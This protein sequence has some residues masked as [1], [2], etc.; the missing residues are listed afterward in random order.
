MSIIYSYPVKGTPSGDDLILISD[1]ASSPQF[2][3]KQIKVSSLPSSGSGITLTTTGTSG[4]AELNGIVLNIPNYSTVPSLPLNG[5]Q[6]RDNNGNFAASSDLKYNSADKTLTVGEQDQNS[7]TLFAAGGQNGT[8][9]PKPGALKLGDD[10]TSGGTITLRAPSDVPSG[11]Y[12]IILP[13]ARPGSNNKILESDANGNLSWIATPSG[14]G[15]GTPQGNDNNVQLKSGTS[16]AGSDD[17]DFDSNVLSVKHTVDIKGQGNSLP[18]GRLKLYCENSSHGVILEGP[19]HS[20][21]TNYTLKFPSA[22]PTN[23][24][25]LQYTTTGSLGWIATPS[26][27]SGISFNG[28]TADGIATYSSASTANVSSNLTIDNTNLKLNIGSTYSAQSDTGI[29]KIGGLSLSQDQESIEFYINGA[30]KVRI[31]EDGRLIASVGSAANPNLKL[32]AG[33]DGIYGSSN[34]VQLITNGTSKISISDGNA[35]DIQMNDLVEFG[36]GLRFGATGET[37]SSY[38]EGSWTPTSANINNISNASG[39]YVKIGKKVFAEFAFTMTGSTSVTLSGLPFSGVYTS[40]NKGA[41]VISVNNCTSVQ[42]QLVGGQMAT[43]TSFIFNA[44]T[45][46]GSGLPTK[47][48]TTTSSLYQTS[49]GTYAGTIIYTAS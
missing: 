44:Y 28:S 1:S 14:G 11:S 48:Q 49:G 22:A 24:Q 36:Y 12:S 29:F 37:L 15:G 9:T 38:E 35:A 32:G 23:N 10:G 41:A 16:F 42:G 47:L 5:I 18:A 3:T 4:V 34:T 39:S 21:A 30:R 8:G 17:L 45:G 13:D 25:I 7:G 31:N 40:N 6:Y 26:G 19:A 46:S 27:G 43:A 33:N 2:A 20:G